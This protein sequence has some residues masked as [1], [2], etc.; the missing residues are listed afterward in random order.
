MMD[1]MGVDVE[2]AYPDGVGWRDLVDLFQRALEEGMADEDT[3][4]A[5]DQ[6]PALL[7]IYEL[8]AFVICGM[9]RLILRA[10]TF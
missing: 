4:F 8:S 3:Y 10:K 6:S 5:K 1:A 7:D 2:E 9:S